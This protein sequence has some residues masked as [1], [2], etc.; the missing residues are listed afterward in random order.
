MPVWESIKRSGKPAVCQLAALAARGAG[1]LECADARHFRY[2]SDAAATHLMVVQP[3]RRPVAAL[4][5]P[6]ARAG[7]TGHAA[8]RQRAG[9]LRDRARRAVRYADPAAGLPRGRLAEPAAAAG[10][11][12][13]PPLGSVPGAAGRLGV[14]TDPQA[15][16]PVGA[17]GD[18]RRPRAEP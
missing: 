7:G 17:G 10:R 8:A 2:P 11:H 3:G 12:A 16:D 13:P 1:P 18:L 9:V 15:H 5:A 14:R 4:A 6:A